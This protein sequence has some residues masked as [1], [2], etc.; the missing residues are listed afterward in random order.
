MSDNQTPYFGIDRIYV[1]D[2]S[3]ENPQAPFIFVQS[4]GSEIETEFDSVANKLDENFFH[5]LL[6]ATVTATSGDKVAFL[7]EVG[8]AGVF[9]IRNVPASELDPILSVTCPNILF[10]YAREVVSDLIVRAG[11]PPVL[12]SPINFE[13]MYLDRLAQQANQA[14]EAPTLQ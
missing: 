13:S 9:Q 8:I 12:L 11:F 6:T 10:P 7:V 1:K 14:A 3:L 5:V 4:E 2:I